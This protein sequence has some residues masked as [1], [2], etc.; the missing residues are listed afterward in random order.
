VRRPTC[1]SVAFALPASAAAEP[2]QVNYEASLIHS[3]LPTNDP[4]V[5]E[6]VGVD[7]L[8][9]IDPLLQDGIFTSVALTRRCS[10]Y[11]ALA[12]RRAAS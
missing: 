3:A 9:F 12:L 6:E 1:A 5:F 11:A 8:D 4:C 10:M 2:V 7:V